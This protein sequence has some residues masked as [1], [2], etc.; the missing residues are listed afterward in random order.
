MSKVDAKRIRKLRKQH[1]RLELQR[2]YW[3]LM[4]QYKKLLSVFETRIVDSE[5]TLRDLEE[6]NRKQRMIMFGII[7]A[8][9]VIGFLA[10]LA[11]LLG[12]ITS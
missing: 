4:E 6:W 10:L 9:V 12:R 1:E 3:K 5:Y 11:I 7:G 2:E 8:V